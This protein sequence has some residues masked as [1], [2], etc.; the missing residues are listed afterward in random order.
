MLV[1]KQSKKVNF[2]VKS[3]EKNAIVLIRKVKRVTE[4]FILSIILYLLIKEKLYLYSYDCKR[5]LYL[6]LYILLKITL[7]ICVFRPFVHFLDKNG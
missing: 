2:S 6:V 4:K 7:D 1:C 3:L 5:I